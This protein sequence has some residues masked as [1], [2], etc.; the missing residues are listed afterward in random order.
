MDEKISD[1]LWW[2]A[3]A[4]GSEWNSGEGW[5]LVAEPAE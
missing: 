1:A 2:R 3:E 5:G 4:E